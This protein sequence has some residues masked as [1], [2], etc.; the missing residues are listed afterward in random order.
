LLRLLGC[1]NRRRLGL[2]LGLA[3]GVRSLLLAYVVPLGLSQRMLL[4]AFPVLFVL[5]A[6]ALEGAGL[7]LRSR[8][9]NLRQN[10]GSP[11]RSLRKLPKPLTRANGTSIARR[12]PTC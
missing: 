1:A 9:E 10:G 5:A 7:L 4:G 2:I 8:L 3:V 12:L 11:N 6:Y